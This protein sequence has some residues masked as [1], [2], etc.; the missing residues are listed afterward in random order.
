MVG[1]GSRPDL[2]RPGWDRGDPEAVGGR[3][4]PG[5][6]SVVVPVAADQEVEVVER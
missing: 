5:T 4:E 1:P 3:L 6:C 2:D